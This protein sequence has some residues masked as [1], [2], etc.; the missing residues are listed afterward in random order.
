MVSASIRNG[1]DHRRTRA[2]RQVAAAGWGGLD[3]EGRA[4]LGRIALLV[5][6]LYYATG[7]PEDATV[8]SDVELVTRQ[9]RAGHDASVKG[10]GDVLRCL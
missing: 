8:R 5:E 7:L 4:A 1:H 2:Q 3:A 10:A 9:L 6:R